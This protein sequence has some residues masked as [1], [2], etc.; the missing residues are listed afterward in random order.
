MSVKCLPP[1]T[2]LLCRKTGV[3]RG[4]PIFL[5]FARK[6]ADCGYKRR[7]GSNVYLQSMFQAKIRKIPNFSDEIFS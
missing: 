2:P 1:Y 3:C 5:N 4:I 6:H 7:G